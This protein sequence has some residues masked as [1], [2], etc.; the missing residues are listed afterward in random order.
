MTDILKSGDAIFVAGHNGMVGSAIV[1]EL[2]SKNFKNIV[3]AS[4]NDVDLIN[5][6]SVTNFFSKV[7]IDYVVLAAAKVGGIHANSKYS[8]QFIYENL[9]IQCNVVHSAFQA[10]V[11][12]LLFLGS[13]CIY[14]KLARQPMAESE[15]L[16]GILEPTNEPYAVAKIA[17]IKLCESYNR[18]YGTHY[19]SVMPTNLYGRGDNFHPENSH[20]IPALMYRFHTAKVSGANS[21]TVWGTGDI[22]RE[23]LH[24]NDM[25]DACVHVMGVTDE[26][27]EANTDA[28]VSHVNVGTGKDITIKELSEI[29][30]EIIGFDGD[31]VFDRTKPDGPPRKLVDVTRIRTMGWQY[32][33][34]LKHG[35]QS[36]YKWYLENFNK[37]LR[38][39]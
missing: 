31:V 36:T 30:K 26:I 16:T 3:T 39:N 5:Q 32:S 34:D 14:P 9:M 6:R 24:V 10:G 1:R 28:M 12:R 38:A 4:H 27:F 21:V 15:L 8:A 37:G 20:V 11:D 33:E 19:R 35:L 23:F 22:K 13:S 29:I 25:A 18:Q 2:E 17:G 7:K